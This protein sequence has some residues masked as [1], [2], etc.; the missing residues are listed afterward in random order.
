MKYGKK[1]KKKSQAER[2]SEEERIC[3]LVFGKE[4]RSSFRLNIS[5]CCCH[6]YGNSGK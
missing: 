2:A 1:Y 5:C 3:F 6:W 4:D